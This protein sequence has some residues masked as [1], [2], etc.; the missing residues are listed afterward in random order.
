MAPK[1]DK[2]TLTKRQ[3]AELI[4]RRRIMKAVVTAAAAVALFIVIVAVIYSASN[5]N[6][7]ANAAATAA[8]TAEATQQAGD[9]AKNDDYARADDPVATIT[10][11]DGGTVTIELYPAAAP[12]TVANFI[13]LANSGFYDGLTFHRV[14]PGFMI[15]GGDPK[16]DGTGGPGYSI[17]GEFVDNGVDNRLTHSRG[18]ISMAR[19]S[20]GYDTAG[21]QFFIIHG[22]A[23]YLDGQYAAFGEVVSGMDVVDQIASVETGVSDKPLED[24]VIQSIT[25]D[26]KGVAYQVEKIED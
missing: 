4:V 5:K 14:I 18:V 25:V 17:K 9:T 11:M 23:T 12:N 24:V 15:Q 10:M 16:G 20:D 21:S 19:S 6:A 26:T 22:D 13:E 1:K 8:P 7:S 3:Q 2:P